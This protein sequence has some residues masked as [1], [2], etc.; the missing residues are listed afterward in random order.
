MKMYGGFENKSNL[1]YNGDKYEALQIY[2]TNTKGTQI[3]TYNTVATTHFISNL[4]LF[5]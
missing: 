1:L 4:A 3:V 5:V 2:R